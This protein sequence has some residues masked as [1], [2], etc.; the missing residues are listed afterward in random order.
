MTMS[1]WGIVRAKEERWMADL[2]RELASVIDRIG[3]TKWGI[4]DITGL[5]PL[6][7]EYPKAVSLA[8]AF[9]PPFTVYDE[10]AYFRL[11]AQIREET[12][13][14]S[15]ELLEVIR[16][17][18]IRNALI[19]NA[20]QNQAIFSH[21]RA[22]VRAGLGWIGKSDLLVTPEFGPRVRLAT[23]LIDAEVDGDAPFTESRCGECQACAGACPARAIQVAR[24]PETG[25]TGLVSA[26]ECN[27]NRER[28]VPALGRKYS[29][30]LCLLA[31]P[32]GQG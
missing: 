12:E 24:N 31:C 27:R 28:T 8:L 23:I 4:G 17:K 5:H 1:G 9:S 3:F 20:L 26:A 15:K 6:A 2:R 32:Y 14:K 30:G 19:P 29:C 18:G 21:K 22:A 7:D 11:S 16:H 25:K 10:P 13:A